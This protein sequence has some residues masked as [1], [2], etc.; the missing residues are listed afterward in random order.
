MQRDGD[1]V[2]DKL[3]P[4]RVRDPP[5]PQPLCVE[6]IRL[7]RAPSAKI[8]AHASAREGADFDVRCALP[9]L[10]LAAE[11]SP[12]EVDELLSLGRVWTLEPESS[13]FGAGKSRGSLYVVIRGSI[14]IC[15][16]G[17]D[18]V[19]RLA[20]LGPGEVAGELATLTA[21][22]ERTIGVVRDGATLLELAAQARIA[23]AHPERPLAYRFAQALVRSLMMQLEL[24]TRALACEKLGL[25]P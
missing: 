2:G 5:R 1:L 25:S 22:P 11:F 18:G 12:E 9:R 14:E 23:L 10:G 21:E 3:G 8:P 7:G 17:G 6:R 16:D 15:F 13:L 24:T 4:L 20:L 19:R